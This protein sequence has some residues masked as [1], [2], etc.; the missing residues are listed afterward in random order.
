MQ[1]GGKTGFGIGP[2]QPADE[3]DGK[4]TSREMMKGLRFAAS[5]ELVSMRAVGTGFVLV[6]G[7]CPAGRDAFSVVALPLP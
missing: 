1:H 3:G 7:G 6:G 5:P 4:E 2:E